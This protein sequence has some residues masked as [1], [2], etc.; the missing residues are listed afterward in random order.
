MADYQNEYRRLSD[1][2][3]RLWVLLLLFRC[4]YLYADTYIINWKR[5]LSFFFFFIL[6]PI[7]I[8]SPPVSAARCRSAIFI[9]VHPYSTPPPTKNTLLSNRIHL[10]CTNDEMIVSYR[11]RFFF[12]FFPIY[13]RSPVGSYLHEKIVCRKEKQ[14]EGY[15]LSTYV[16]NLTRPTDILCCTHRYS[17][18]HRENDKK[19]IKNRVHAYKTAVCRGRY[20]FV[21]TTAVTNLRSYQSWTYRLHRKSHELI[22]LCTSLV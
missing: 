10:P 7:P 19:K 20:R 11:D 14:K 22:L 12:F 8:P 5:F 13:L 18:A 3:T 21:G 15:K 9:R 4:V 2:I 6:I 1:N 16:Y 17:T